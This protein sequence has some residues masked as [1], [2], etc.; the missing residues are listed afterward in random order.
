MDGHEIETV[1]EMKLL[2]LIVRNDLSWSSNTE[3][4][5][6]KGYQRLWMIKRLK[7]LGG[8]VESLTDVYCKQ[9]RSVLEFGAPVWNS[10]INKEKVCDIERVQKSFLHIV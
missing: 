4:I 5:T 9:I 8:S 7:K 2:G 1:E 6:K 3:E 10:G